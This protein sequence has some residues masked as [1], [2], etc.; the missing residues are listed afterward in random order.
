MVKA[1]KI[2][3]VHPGEI[4]LELLE[5][6]N[7]T[8]VA[9]ARKLHTTHARINEICNKKRG[10]TDKMAKKLSIFF[11]QSPQFWANLQS[12]WELSQ[13]DDED[14]ENIEPFKLRA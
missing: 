5:Q 9:L 14:F 2:I 7:L 4:L 12:S 10:I 13:L 6:N 8:Q 3:A 1:R 11:S